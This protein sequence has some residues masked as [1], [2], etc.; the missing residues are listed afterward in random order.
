[1]G[2]EQ[3]S[4][5]Y[6]DEHGVFPQLGRGA[7][8][9]REEGCGLDDALFGVEI[10]QVNVECYP[11]LARADCGRC[12]AF[13]CEIA[14]AY[15]RGA[16]MLCKVFHFTFG[17]DDDRGQIFERLLDNLAEGRTFARPARSLDQE[18]A[19]K[20]FVEI[21]IEHTAGVLSDRYPVAGR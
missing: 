4:F 20:Q 17:V 16:D 6:A 3:V 11:M 9:P 2:C 21:E 10:G 13:D 7:H 5:I 18:T 1:M 12:H 15:R 19:C 14:C 8:E